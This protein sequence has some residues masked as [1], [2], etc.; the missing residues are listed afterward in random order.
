MHH[1]LYGTEETPGLLSAIDLARYLRTLNQRRPGPWEQALPPQWASLSDAELRTAARDLAV[2]AD[3]LGPH[4]RQRLLRD[5][6]YRVCDGRLQDERGR[7]LPLPVLVRLLKSL[8]STFGHFFLKFQNTHPQNAVLL[9]DAH[10]SDPHLTWRNLG[11]V[12][13]GLT[14]AAR[15]EGLSSIIKTGPIDLAGEAIGHILAENPD[16]CPKLEA[17]QADLR[18]G[19]WKPAMTFQVG[20]PLAGSEVVD[21]DTP[22]AHSGLEERRRDRRPPRALFSHHYWAAPAAHTPA[23]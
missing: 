3:W 14:W 21:A 11:R 18:S 13:A 2:E 19:R 1:A 12:A 16:G 23:P 9:A 4:L 6:K 20:H 5:G 22:D 17:W 10:A 7:A 15:A 8:A